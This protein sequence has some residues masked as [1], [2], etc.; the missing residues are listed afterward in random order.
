[1]INSGILNGL[2]VKDAIHKIIGEIVS[3]QIGKEK[4]QYRMRD[5]NFSRQRYWGSHS[6]SSMTMKGYAIQWKNQNYL[7]HFP[8]LTKSARVPVAN[9]L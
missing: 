4:V 8:K 1:M 2:S 5:A 9:H 6:Q 3:R 7:S